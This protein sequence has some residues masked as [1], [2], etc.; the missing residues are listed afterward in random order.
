MAWGAGHDDII[1]PPGIA[2]GRVGG[3]SFLTEVIQK[4]NSK[5]KRNQVWEIGAAKWDV[6]KNLK[7]QAELNTIINF[8]SARRAKAF[9]FWI[10]DVIDYEIGP[11]PQLIEVAPGGSHDIQIF[12]TYANAGDPRP[13]YHPIYKVDN[14][15]VYDNDT[16]TGS[17]TFLEGILTHS[18]I[19]SHTVKITCTFYKV[20]RFDSDH[21]PLSL[22]TY[23][24]SGVGIPVIELK[25]P[26]DD[27]V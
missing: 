10:K 6:S 11:T 24:F 19:A 26:F 5:E 2:Y 13:Y 8:F 3:I 4:R 21:L 23:N 25:D 20:A 22:D 9:S 17:Y 14:L 16:P 12:K 18:F 7:S 27:E 15:V 1:F